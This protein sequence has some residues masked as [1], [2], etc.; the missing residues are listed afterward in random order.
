M[1]DRLDDTVLAVVRL[2]SKSED[3]DDAADVA[4][5]ENDELEER[6]STVESGYVSTPGDSGPNPGFP[7]TV[8]TVK[9]AGREIF[10]ERLPGLG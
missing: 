6:L 7:S 3:V 9:L 5:E 8:G 1:A 4:K 10:G 2:G